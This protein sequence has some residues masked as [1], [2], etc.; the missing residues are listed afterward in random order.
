[1]SPSWWSIW[2]AGTRPWVLPPSTSQTEC[3]GI[4]LNLSAQE[5]RAEVQAILGYRVSSSPVRA[6]E[7]LSQENQNA[8][9]NPA[10][11]QCSG[12]SWESCG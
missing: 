3:T 9:E 12:L 7:T 1:M 11:N 8:L 6:T 5:V 10:G 2:L 4:C